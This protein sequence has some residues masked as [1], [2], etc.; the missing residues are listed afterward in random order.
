MKNA[1]RGSSLIALLL[2]CAL[3]GLLAV[4]MFN[5]SHKLKGF[6]GAELH[7]KRASLGAVNAALET[8][9]NESNFPPLEPFMCRETL[10]QHGRTSIARQLC[11][12]RHENE[13]EL[14]KQNII[15]GSLLPETK[16]FPAFDYNQLFKAA[17]YCPD[18]VFDCRAGQSPGGAILAA[19]GAC[20]RFLCSEPQLSVQGRYARRGNLAA[21]KLL[22]P[23]SLSKTPAVLAASGF[24]EIS[25][26]AVIEND[27]LI[28]A[29]GDLLINEISAGDEVKITL[30]SASGKIAV[31]SFSGQ[32]YLK[33]I[34][35]RGV[36]IP[37]L[38][39][40]AHMQ[41]PPLRHLEVLGLTTTG[42]E[43]FSSPKG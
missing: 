37:S 20:S 17:E 26:V 11:A 35:R 43:E 15:D 42:A 30:I 6:L 4:N 8:L 3:L 24:I 1:E 5:T 22:V 13:L 39:H 7:S 12:V 31:Q 41:L 27:F 18:A 19:L 38:S 9:I 32:A 16:P 33:A 34:G 29:G 40:P 21:A 23:L 25:S 2:A 36:S 14:L 28:I 10:A